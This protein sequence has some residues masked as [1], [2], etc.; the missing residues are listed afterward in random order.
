LDRPDRQSDRPTLIAGDAFRVVRLSQMGVP[1]PVSIV[2]LLLERGLGLL[3]LCAITT[4]ASPVL[5]SLLFNRTDAWL[6]A[7]CAILGL[8]AT[9]LLSLSAVLIDQKRDPIPL[10]KSLLRLLEFGVMFLRQVRLSAAATALAMLSQFLACL[11]VYMLA[12]AAGV[13]VSLL[14]CLVLMPTILFATMLPISI[15]GWGVRE[16]AMVYLFTAASV[17]SADALALS[18]QF[19]LLTLVA[20]LPGVLFIP[21]NRVNG[22]P[23]A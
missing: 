15:G 3:A 9:A 14:L 8:C 19:G 4:V 2:S 18:I 11:A 17:P 12:R 23:N 21:I 22:A 16:S 10:P 20:A 5:L 13:D 7:I 1:T 6:I